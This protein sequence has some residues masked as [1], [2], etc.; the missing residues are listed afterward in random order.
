MSFSPERRKSNKSIR[1]FLKFMSQPPFGRCKLFW[2][3]HTTHVF[4]GRQA[5]GKPSDSLAAIGLTLDPE[6]FGAC[7]PWSGFTMRLQTALRRAFEVRFK[8]AGGDFHSG[9]LSLPR[10]CPE[11]LCVDC[12]SHAG[13]T[14]PAA[15]ELLGTTKL[16]MRSNSSLSMKSW[17]RHGKTALHSRWKSDWNSAAKSCRPNPSQ[18]PNPSQPP[19]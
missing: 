17:G 16:R 10:N 7:V 3:E 19:G 6:P 1:L 5:C 15:M 11:L 12:R 14:L 8:Q 13:A 4:I 2:V 18:S 9:M